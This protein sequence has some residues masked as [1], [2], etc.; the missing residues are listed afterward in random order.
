MMPLATGRAAASGAA[1]MALGPGPVAVDLFCGAGG[2][3]YGMQLAG[4]GIAAGI[5]LDPD[6]EHPFEV[7]VGAPFRKRDVAGMS[8]SELSALY[9][10]ELRAGARGMRP[11]PALLLLH[12]V[13]DR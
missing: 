2:L 7:N 10:D 3:A 8:A 5:D 9:P 6:C 13:R 11:V 12:E 4:V 1:G